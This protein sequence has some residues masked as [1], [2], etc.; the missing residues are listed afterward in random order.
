MIE[1]GG[2]DKPLGIRV[3]EALSRAI[4]SGEFGEGGRLPSSRGLA[5][6]LGV[7]RNTVNTAYARL[8]AEGFISI[9]PA[10]GA[11]AVPG[12]RLAEPPRRKPEKNASVGFP[13]KRN[14]I[15]DF[16]SGLPDG[17][18]FPVSRWSRA[19]A[20]ALRDAP[21]S[22]FGYGA[23]E[24]RPELRA[25]IAAYAMRYRA[26]RCPP[27][28]VLV[29]A[30]TTQAIGIIGRALFGQGRERRRIAV[31]ED[32]LT[33]DIKS[34]L[35]GQ[36]AKIVPVRVDAH[37]LDPGRIAPGIEPALIYVTPSHQFPTGVSMSV[38]RR[39]ELLDYARKSG[40][41]VVEDD[42]DSEFMFR[43][44][45]PPSLQGLD[46]ERVIYV[47]TFS[48]TL[49]PALRTAYVIF[50]PGLLKA[51]REA[52]WL[53]DLHNPVIDQL[54]LARFISEGW[55][56]RHIAAMKGIYRR[57]RIFFSSCLEVEARRAG[58][59]LRLLGDPCGLHLAAR[60]PGRSFTRERLA[61]LEADGVKVYPVSAHALRPR[62]WAD[63]LILGYGS[64]DEEELGR[65]A[66]I[67]MESLR[68]G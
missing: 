56:A 45:P 62:A 39:I 28:G 23:P 7:S 22:A 34:I 59:R 20:A 33:C 25:A 48:K 30:G 49:S 35:S 31:V 64:L 40:A 52:K 6:L 54:A 26:T 47:G 2:G 68:R 51:A 61:R 13:E 38:K 11:F 27:D 32:P 37:G 1:L 58:L 42:Y 44:Q 12:A 55:Y 66:R 10:S 8:E 65:G 50:P 43:G 46:P 4:L 41:Y 14:D 21:P 36:G 24:G 9:R 60:F 53:S 16:K 15:V 5:E 18:F 19:M 57:R 63:A 17:R 3:Y 67:L 29:A